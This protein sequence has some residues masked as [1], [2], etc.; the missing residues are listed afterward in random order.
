MNSLAV[1]LLIA[2]IVLLIVEA[3]I[4]N[5]GICGILGIVSFFGS[6]IITV[7]YVQNGIY[8]VLLEFVIFAVL[9]YLAFKFIFKRKFQNRVVL[10]ETLQVS[11][12]DVDLYELLGKEGV[13]TTPLK[14]TGFV[15]FNGTV[16]EA[17]SEGAYINEHSR[18]KVI[19]RL[20]NK[21]IV[22]LIKEPNAN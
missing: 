5:F 3:F 12:P 14:P 6:A 16:I 7:I 13:V 18:V 11:K 4:P 8:I 20:N 2:A 19:D 22:R 21:P 1:L 9:L 10:N 15:D 17:C